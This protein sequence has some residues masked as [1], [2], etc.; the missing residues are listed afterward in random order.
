MIRIQIEGEP[1]AVRSG[2]KDGRLWTRREQ[3]AYVHLGLAF[4]QPFLL[5]LGETTA[6][7]APGMY[8]I[9]PGSLKVGQ[10]GDLQFG[11]EIKLIPAEAKAKA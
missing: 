7:Y 5:N 2:N 6:P 1:I 10:Y 11:R 4:P 9:D 8:T 3:R